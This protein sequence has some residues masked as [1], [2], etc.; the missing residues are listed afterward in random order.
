M[1]FIQGGGGGGGVTA[2]AHFNHASDIVADYRFNGTLDSEGGSQVL[3]E[4]GGTAQYIENAWIPGFKAL[5]L[6]QDTYLTRLDAVFR[7]LGDMTL[8]I[9]YQMTEYVASQGIA[10]IITCQGDPFSQAA[11]ENRLWKLN[12]ACDEDSGFV[13]LSAA[14]Q[15][16]DTPNTDEFHPSANVDGPSPFTGLTFSEADGYR[17]AYAMRRSG[18]QY[19]FFNQDRQIGPTSGVLTAPDGGSN[20]ELIIGTSDGDDGLGIV[21]QQVMIISAALAD[22]AILDQ[23]GR[24]NTYDPT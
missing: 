15:H 17:R 4:N 20:A 1:T 6:D 3:T 24:I 22:Q 10:A 2:P 16:G 14:H 18:N 7:L 23:L 9:A 19:S 13:M 21:I 5:F 12:F 8:L 11:A